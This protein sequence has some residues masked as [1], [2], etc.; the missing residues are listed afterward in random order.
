MKCIA[1]TILPSPF[2]LH[3]HRR[4][5]FTARVRSTTGGYVFTRVCL[6][7]GRV[8][9]H[10]PI[11]LTGPISFPGV[12]HLHTIIV[13]LVPGPFWGYPNPAPEGGDTTIQS[14]MGRGGYPSQIPMGIPHLQ[15]D[16]GT[17]HQDWMGFPPQ[18]RHGW[19]SPSWDLD[20]GT[21]PI[22]TGW[23]TPHQD[24][25]GVSPCQNWMGVPLG[26]D[27]DGG[28]PPPS[29]TGWHL[30]RLCCGWYTSCS[31]Q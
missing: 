12:V 21:P 14:Q 9:H 7:T 25:I 24:W 2:Q 6:L 19:G 26:W 22:S 30:D 4:H 13:P 23:G 16:V 18:L 5:F 1:I 31:F 17:P 11:I 15:L 28:I 20:G 8:P 3:V 10:H 29:E 27:L